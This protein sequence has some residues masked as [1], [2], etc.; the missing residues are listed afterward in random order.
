VGSSLLTAYQGKTALVTGGAGAV[1]GNLV[2]ALCVQGCTKVIVLDDLS[3]SSQWLIPQGEQIRFVEGDV[4]DEAAL[5]QVFLERPDFVFHLAAFFANQNSVE[6]PETDLQVNGL[7]TLRVLEYA[8]MVGVERFIY[9]SSGASFYDEFAPLPLSEDYMTLH[10]TT[11]YKATKMLGE[12]YCNFFHH[13]YGLSAVKTR[14]FNSYGPGEVPGRYRNVIPNFIDRAMRGL[15]LII[16]GTGNE[17]RDFTYVGDLVEG[18]LRAGVTEGVEGESFNL[19]AGRETQIL[20]LAEMINGVTGNSA[21][22]EFAERRHW[23][24][25]TRRW[26][27]TTKAKNLLGYKPKTALEEGLRVTIRWFEEKW[28]WINGQAPDRFPAFRAI[29]V[30]TQEIAAQPV[31][32]S[33][34]PKEQNGQNGHK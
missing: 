33:V 4:T 2:E 24:T 23:D 1:G 22:I 15:P 5:K 19:A 18:I 10:H 9:A 13:H 32:V 16:T 31:L 29:P 11:P 8:Q 17:T 25:Q 26:A 21:G 6:H 20:E 7:G 34:G 27:S 30:E 12:V 3:A 14:F 28:D